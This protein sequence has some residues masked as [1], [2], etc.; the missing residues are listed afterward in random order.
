MSETSDSI[1]E[2]IRLYEEAIRDARAQGVPE[3]ELAQD[4][5]NVE[6]LRRIAEE[7]DKPPPAPV[8]RTR[9]ELEMMAFAERLAARQGTFIPDFRALFEKKAELD[10]RLMDP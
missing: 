2:N 4:E 8:E 5:K 3:H 7:G 9:E 6:T 1:R 10:R